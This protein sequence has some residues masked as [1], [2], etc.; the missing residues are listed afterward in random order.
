[1]NFIKSTSQSIMIAF[2]IECL[3]EEHKFNQKQIDKLTSK[4]NELDKINFD[5]SKPFCFIKDFKKFKKTCDEYEKMFISF[6]GDISSLENKLKDDMNVLKK[7]L[8]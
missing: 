6:G 5:I 8:N 7:S 1:M 2:K 3:K 4:A